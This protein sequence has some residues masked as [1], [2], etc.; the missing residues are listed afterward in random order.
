MT[1]ELIDDQRAE[2]ATRL[3][4][5]HHDIP[6]EYSAQEGTCC[7]CAVEGGGQHVNNATSKKYFSDDPLLRVPKSDHVCK[8]CSWVM[9]QRT[10]KQ[11]H[12]LAH[13]TGTETP[14]TGDL[15]KLFCELRAGEYDPPLAI[16]VTSSPIRSSHSYLWTPVN[17]STKPLSVAYDRETVRIED[18]QAFA[19]LVAAIEDLRLHGFTFDEIRN[20]EPRVYNV[21]SIGLSMYRNREQIIEPNRRTARLELALTLSRSGDDQA[22]TDLTD[23]Y[24]PLTNE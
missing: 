23:D 12:W 15:L 22:R 24:D 13:D 20:G 11:G 5:S 16:H 9:A 21:E 18:W 8:Q 17:I 4:A 7:F 1:V 6:D 14:S 2:T 3:L 10:Y 19:D